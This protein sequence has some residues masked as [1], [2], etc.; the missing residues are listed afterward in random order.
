[1][2]MTT[3]AG[4]GGGTTE[5]DTYHHHLARLLIGPLPTLGMLAASAPQAAVGEDPELLRRHRCRRGGAAAIVTEMV[6][7]D[8]L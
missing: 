6:G 4:A 5:N 1:M 7:R 8:H 2:T 3:G